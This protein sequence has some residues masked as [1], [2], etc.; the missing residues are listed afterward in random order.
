[1]TERCECGAGV[2]VEGNALNIQPHAIDCATLQEIVK[3]K[4][5]VRLEGE[6]ALAFFDAA[7]S[8]WIREE[9]NK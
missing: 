9:L 2:W 4:Q 3:T 7:G 8:G 5:G 6:E 1:M